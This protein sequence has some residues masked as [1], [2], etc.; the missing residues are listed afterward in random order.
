VLDLSNYSDL[1]IGIGE[2]PKLNSEFIQ[3]KSGESGW[4]PHHLI[5]LYDKTD[6]DAQLDDMVTAL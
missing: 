2:A 4:L 3:R 6:T 1:F 5:D